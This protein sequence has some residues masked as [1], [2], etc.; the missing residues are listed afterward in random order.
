[1]RIGIDIG[2][3]FTDVVVLED[4]EVLRSWKV[5]STPQ[6]FEE[7]VLNG[8]ELAAEELSLSVQEFLGSTTHFIHGTTVT[9]N[10]VLTRSGERVGLITSD[11]FGDTYELARQY[12]GH[13]QDPAK[14]THPAPL[15]PRQ[16]V[17]EVT[18]R[19]D[20]SGRVVAPLNEAVDL[21]DGHDPGDADHVVFLEQDVVAGELLIL[22]LMESL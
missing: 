16:D 19:I 17:E 9:T 5:Q 22:I 21:D 6:N 7:G 1:M 15:V 2:G 3:T 11:G 4:G 13:E 12:R 18:E 20:Y 10:L 14:V 8:I